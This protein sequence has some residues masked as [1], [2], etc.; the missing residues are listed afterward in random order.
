MKVDRIWVAAL[1]QHFHGAGDPQT[2]DKIYLSVESGGAEI[3]RA[4]LA[5]NPDG[6]FARG[7]ANLVSIETP[8]LVLDAP[9]FSRSSVRIGVEG[10]DAWQPSHLF[11][12]AE[13][14]QSLLPKPF[15]FPLAL[16]SDWGTT[17]STDPSEGAANAE[18]SAIARGERN[19][20]ISRLLFIVSNHPIPSGTYAQHKP[21]FVEGKLGLL[22]NSENRLL[23]SAMIGDTPQDAVLKPRGSYYSDAE[24]IAAR[25]NYYQPHVIQPFSRDALGPGS[26]AAIKRGGDYWWPQHLFVFG[27]NARF[28]RHSQI[29]PLV[30]LPNWGNTAGM[31]LSFD[32]TTGEIMAP[33][34]LVDEG[35]DVSDLNLDTEFPT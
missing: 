35:I 12:W 5:A 23:V 32:A 21:E 28:G 13:T 8:G 17:L 20:R 24:T 18:L 22:V 33:L 34:P 4:R 6:G 3:F 7:R 9:P 25:S 15:I 11:V 30:Y 10:D 16:E 29:V 31:P 14:A 26:I 1:T 19:M 27:L 2:A